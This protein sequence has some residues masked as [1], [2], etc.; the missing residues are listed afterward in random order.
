M[1][2]VKMKE[3]NVDITGWEYLKGRD[4]YIITFRISDLEPEKREV[5]L[6]R[7]KSGFLK[8]QGAEIE[9]I[10][11]IG[12]DLYVKEYYEK[13]YFENYKSLIPLAQERVVPERLDPDN[14]EIEVEMC[15]IEQE[16]K[17]RMDHAAAWFD[18][19]K[20]GT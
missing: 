3:K 5:I 8:S 15:I 4:E 20:K 18:E 19:L 14:L 10:I 7:Y 16:M 2:M 9:E 12:E 13:E 1:I 11:E 6:E 17:Y